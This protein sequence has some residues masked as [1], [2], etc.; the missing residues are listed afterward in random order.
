MT[1]SAEI[2]KLRAANTAAWD[3]YR[4]IISRLPPG[5]RSA[6]VQEEYAAALDAADRAKFALDKALIRDWGRR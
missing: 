5:F 6:K 3:Y 2:D 4:Y 1:N